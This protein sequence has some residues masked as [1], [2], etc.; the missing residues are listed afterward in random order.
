MIK[1]DSDSFLEQFIVYTSF[2]MVVSCRVDI[3]LDDIPFFQGH[4]ASLDYWT[5]SRY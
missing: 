4:F 1:L 3:C 5:N 2:V